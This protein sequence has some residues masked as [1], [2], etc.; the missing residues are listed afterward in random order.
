LNKTASI[1]VVSIIFILG[2]GIATQPVILQEG[3]PFP[4]FLAILKL[5]LLY[6]DVA[7]ISQVKYVQK[8]GSFEP[9]NRRLGLMGWQFIE[10]MGAGLIYS[11]NGDQL[12]VMHRM[13]TSRYY[14]Y[15][16]ERPLLYNWNQPAGCHCFTL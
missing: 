1:I 3:N 6:T 15:E 8:A 5:E 13:L 4:V 9:F 12:L 7:M 11:N 10:Q 2:I 16:L 14:I